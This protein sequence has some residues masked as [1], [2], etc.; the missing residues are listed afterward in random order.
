[1]LSLSLYFS[2]LFFFSIWKCSWGAGKG[3]LENS[4]GLREEKLCPC[5]A[6]SL[7]SDQAAPQ[8]HPASKPPAR[9]P[10]P[11][12]AVE[13]SPPPLVFTALQRQQCA[14]LPGYTSNVLSPPATPASSVLNPA[15]AEQGAGG[16]R[17]KHPRKWVTG[18]PRADRQRSTK[19]LCTWD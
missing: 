8:R 9:L 6:L 11:A 2:T 13:T 10:R 5:P 14:A 4:R 18:K 17:R 15:A 3:R 16:E 7:I 19:I 12:A 1:M